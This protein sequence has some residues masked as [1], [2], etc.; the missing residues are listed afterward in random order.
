MAALLLALLGMWAWQTKAAKN[1]APTIGYS[2]FF[3]LVEQGKVK[4][5]VLTGQTLEVELSSKQQVAGQTSQKFRTLSP[6]DD[7]AL[8]PLLRQKQVELR[9]MSEEPPLLLT[10]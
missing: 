4:S 6:S 5:V 7:V 3:A 9:V 2:S 10:C 8:L 1:Q